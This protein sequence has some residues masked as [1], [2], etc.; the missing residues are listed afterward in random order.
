MRVVYLYKNKITKI[1]NLQSFG[2]NLTHLYLQHNKIKNLENFETLVNL[3]K[4]YLDNNQ[5]EVVENLENLCK[6]EELYISNQELPQGTHMTFQ[7]GSMKALSSKLT[8]L[9]A[10]S[11]QI[12]DVMNLGWFE[13]LTNLVLSRN[14]IENMEAV[15]FVLSSNMNLTEFDISNNPINKIHKYRNKIIVASGRNLELLDGVQ[16]TPNEREFI[17]NLELKKKGNS[18]ETSTKS[19]PS[20]NQRAP[21]L[22]VGEKQNPS[23]R[24][25]PKRQHSSKQQSKK[26]VV[27]LMEGEFL[28]VSR[29]K[30]ERET[31]ER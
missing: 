24:V 5:I 4:L 22:L 9:C 20:T 1:E 28:T 11:C 26:I 19:S 14:N 3:Q 16:I 15:Q 30:A 8:V 21:P 12:V 29:V 7:E 6:L 2:K 17:H 23:F 27:D 31:Q 25:S 10:S 18:N 13:N